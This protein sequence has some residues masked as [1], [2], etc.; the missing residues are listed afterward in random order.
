MDRRT[1][2]SFIINYSKR[3]KGSRDGVNEG[4]NQ[5]NKTVEHN[6]ISFASRNWSKDSVLF[7]VVLLFVF[8]S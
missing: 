2:F 1:Y 4:V 7:L 8:I 6:E 3:G 5:R